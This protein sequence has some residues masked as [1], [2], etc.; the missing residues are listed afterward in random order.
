[1][2]F[3]KAISSFLWFD[4][5]ESIG[6]RTKIYTSIPYA[7]WQKLITITIVMITLI[8]CSN[9]D[10]DD[11]QSANTD[12]EYSISG[13]VSSNISGDKADFFISTPTGTGT[14]NTVIRIN[15]DDANLFIEIKLDD[16][17]KGTF[18]IN[19]EI[20]TDS[21][22]NPIIVQLEPGEAIA[23]MQTGGAL[24]QS[25]RSFHTRS[26][27]GGVINLTGVN[28]NSITGNFDISL[29]TLGGPAD[30]GPLLEV[31]VKGEFTAIKF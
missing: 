31:N 21:N 20:G 30:P 10:L 7:A 11:T 8:G 14:K 26:A 27:K 16:P 19:N 17:V 13:D 9:D 25:G 22:G 3:L 15:G 23:H 12:F 18:P 29:M 28:A 24:T 5:H 1:M 6:I 4:S 2:K